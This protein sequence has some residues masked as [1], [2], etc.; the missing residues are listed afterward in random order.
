MKDELAKD[1]EES[2]KVTLFTASVP[3]STFGY[4]EENKSPL[5]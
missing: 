4:V 2:E 5:C 1:V 3:K